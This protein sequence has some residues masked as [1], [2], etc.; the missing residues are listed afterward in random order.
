MDTHY[1]KNIQ[2]IKIQSCDTAQRPA[3]SLELALH[4]SARDNI[5]ELTVASSEFSMSR[6]TFGLGPLTPSY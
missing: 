2:N 6:Q 5:A 1:V 3:S 4:H